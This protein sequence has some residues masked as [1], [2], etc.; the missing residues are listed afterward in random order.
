MELKSLCDL[1]VKA[2]KEVGTFIQQERLNGFT[3]EEKSQN[4]LVTRVDKQAEQRLVDA[5]KILLPEAGILGEEGI[6]NKLTGH[7]NWIIDPLDG[8][9][10]FIHGIP[11]YCI[12]VALM[13]KDELCIGVVYELNL[14][15]CFYAWKNG[16]AYLNGNPIWVS[17]NENV[18]DALVATG[19]PY[20][21][22]IKTD[23]YLSL[24]KDMMESTRGIRRLGSAAVDLAYVACGRFDCFYEYSLQAWDVAA[25]ALIVQEA[26][27]TVCDFSGSTNFVFGK[28]IVASSAT[29]SN[30]FLA[31]IN[32]HF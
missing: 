32:T 31:K 1:T 2:V 16:G 6:D 30:A 24:L 8:T 18:S 28:E 22:F 13:H 19:F 21:D 9:T 25:G 7:Y 27:G 15:E 17:K 20:Y 23:Q 14:H 4:S 11:C 3:V 26:G 12:S 10:N 5:L 29:L